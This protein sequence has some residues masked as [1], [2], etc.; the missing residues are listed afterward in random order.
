ML[1]TVPEDTEPPIS[2]RLRCAR[3]AFDAF[4]A[5][6]T[7]YSAIEQVMFLHVADAVIESLSESREA[8]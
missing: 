7:P 5:E 2:V 4:Y 8:V 6:G 3:A 1:D